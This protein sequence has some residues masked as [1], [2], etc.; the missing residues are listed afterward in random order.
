MAV[1]IVQRFATLSCRSKIHLETSQR[2]MLNLSILRGK[3]LVRQ[4]E[5]FIH[6]RFF[7]DTSSL[8]K[9]KLGGNGIVAGEN[10][11]RLQIKKKSRNRILINNKILKSNVSSVIGKLL[12]NIAI[13]INN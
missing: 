5:L 11:S 3:T 8:L 1:A 12:L 9:N 2:I 13:K 10:V 6:K 4:A 7:S